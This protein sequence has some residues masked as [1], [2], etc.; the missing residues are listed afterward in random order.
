VTSYTAETTNASDIIVV[1]PV[2]PEATVSI[3]L[4][5]GTAV[6]NGQ[7][8]SWDEGENT[9]EITVTNGTATKVYTVT[10]TKS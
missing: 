3:D 5:H 6:T 4:N 10:V 2:D 1:T 7:A 9:L 8:A